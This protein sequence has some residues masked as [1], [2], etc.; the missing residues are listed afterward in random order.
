M[1]KRIFAFALMLISGAYLLAVT[2]FSE[3]YCP[4]RNMAN[5]DKFPP[6]AFFTGLGHAQ[7]I[8]AFARKYKTSC[9]TCHTAFPNLTPFGEAFKRNGLRFPGEGTVFESPHALALG[10]ESD[11]KEFPKSVWP[12]AL[13]DSVPLSITGASEF[14]SLPKS[15]ATNQKAQFQQFGGGISLLAADTLGKHFA[16]WGGLDF[17]SNVNLSTGVKTYEV[18]VERAY[19]VINPLQNASHLVIRVG[20][21]EPHLLNVSAHRSLLGD[22]F[23][24]TDRTVGNNGFT[25]EGSQQGVEFGGAVAKGRL[26]YTLGVVEGTGNRYNNYK[27]SYGRVEYKFGGLRFDGVEDDHSK[28]TEHPWRDDSLTVGAFGYLGFASLVTGAGAEQQDRFYLLGGDV[29]ANFWNFLVDVGYL[30]QKN[31]RPL[32]ATP[33]ISVGTNQIFAEANYVYY[34]FLPGVRYEYFDN[35][36]TRDHRL[37]VGATFL[38]RP[39][40]KTYLRGGLTKVAAGKFTDNP[41]ISAGLTIGF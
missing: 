30:R 20:S 13:P 19:A 37:T 16:Y 15:S 10:D 26:G 2:L 28:T 14:S 23:S 32:L 38:V 4:F 41:E 8:P 12:G 34:W 17:S 6:P 36:Q 7:A 39:N 29:H 31:N 21:F 1:N 22:Y 33:T 27:D 18:G 24:T 5:A 25:L 11:K 40:I 35:S 9:Q 3:E